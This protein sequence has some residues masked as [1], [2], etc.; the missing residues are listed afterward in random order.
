M[1]IFK[2]IMQKLTGRKKCYYLHIAYK[3][4]FGKSE[5]LESDRFFTL[6]DCTLTELRQ[7]IQNVIEKEAGKQVETLSLVNI[8]ELSKGLFDMLTRSE[9][10][11]DLHK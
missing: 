4:Q 10:F 6:H 9:T 3:A 8:T 11:N 1:N 2:K 5:W 7:S